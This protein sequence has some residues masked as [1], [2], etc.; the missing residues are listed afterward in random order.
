MSSFIS[1][2]YGISYD[3]NKHC[4]VGLDK[5]TVNQIRADIQSHNVVVLKSY[6]EKSELNNLKKNFHSLFLQSVS[7]NPPL[8][9]NCPNFYRRDIDPPLSAVKRNKQFVTS[10]YWNNDFFGERGLFISLSKLRN[11]IAKLPPD[12]T[13]SGFEADGYVTYAN[14]T[15]YPI[16]GGKLNKHTDPPNK[17]FCTIMAAMSQKGDDFLNGGLYVEIDSQKIDIDEFLEI[18][19]VYLMNPQT[20]HGV[21]IVDAE[22]NNEI[23]WNSPKGRWILFPALIEAKSALGVKV[24]GLKDLEENENK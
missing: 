15:H 19:D 9:P 16:N 4:T 20:I 13:L 1:N 10:F 24:E 5:N 6:F 11:I 2:Y 17:Q 22:E 18:G 3:R 7:S 21:D 12:Y 23:N 8:T 14:I